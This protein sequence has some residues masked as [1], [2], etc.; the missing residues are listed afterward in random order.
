VAESRARAGLEAVLDLQRIIQ[1]LKSL[2]I[3]VLITD[4]NVR[5]TLKI[6]DRTYIIKDGR[7]FASGHPKQLADDPAVRRIY[8]GEDFRL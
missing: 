3:G 7:I 8:L 4:H 1:H 2:K 5:E 6:T